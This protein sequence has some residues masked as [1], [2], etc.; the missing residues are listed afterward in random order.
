MFSY[1]KKLFEAITDA[2]SQ[3]GREIYVDTEYS[4][5]SNDRDYE[6]G[7]RIYVSEF[8]RAFLGED[9]FKALIETHG[10]AEVFYYLIMQMRF[11]YPKFFPAHDL[12]FL[13]ANV[14]ACQIKNPTNIV[15]LD[16]ELLPVAVLLSKFG[17]SI[18]VDVKNSEDRRAICDLLNVHTQSSWQALGDKLPENSYILSQNPLCISEGLAVEN[19]AG[20]VLLVN[21]NFLRLD[22]YTHA[23]REWVKSK[24]VE[25]VVQ[26][27]RPRRQAVNIYPSII[28]LSNAKQEAIVMSQ[29]VG[30]GFGA[31]SLDMEQAL[32]QMA[33]GIQ[34]STQS[35]LQS[36]KCD[37]TPSVH[38]AEYESDKAK[39]ITTLG[40]VAHVLRCQIPRTVFDFDLY[41]ESSSLRPAFENDEKYKDISGLIYKEIGL[42]NIDQ[43]SGFVDLS[44]TQDVNLKITSM[45]KQG[46][47]LLQPDDIVMNFRGSLDSLGKVGFVDDLPDRHLLEQEDVDG[48]SVG[49]YVASK[50][51]LIIRPFAI[52]PA[53]LFGYLRKEL[54]K[55]DLTNQAK[56]EGVKTITIEN[57]KNI[58]IPKCSAEDVQHA[59]EVRQEVADLMNKISQIYKEIAMKQGS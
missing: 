56:G 18:Y 51:M 52:D 12:C 26:V 37:L 34:V 58:Q 9:D 7:I 15:L 55:E 20:G 47:Y 49:G 44:K 46:K 30:T 3:E 5:P 6:K 8:E 27:P 35:L 28:T 21:I 11:R 29:V 50:S 39:N 31:G 16:F 54:V 36:P 33:T 10:I 24:L 41:V 13:L 38:L 23:R 32:H 57:V 17:A 25:N 59:N 40:D 2:I 43:V 19:L 48:T 1:D 22:I 42:A 4:S 45:G 53:W 14:L